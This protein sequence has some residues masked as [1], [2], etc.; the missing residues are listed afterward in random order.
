M[1]L[2]NCWAPAFSSFCF[3]WLLRPSV[4][5]WLV[6]FGSSNVTIPRGRP[7]PNICAHVWYTDVH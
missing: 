3:K 2:Y 6:W 1:T 7:N 5:A 4:L